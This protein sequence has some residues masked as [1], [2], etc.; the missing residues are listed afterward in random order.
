MKQQLYL[1]RL[2]LRHHLIKKMFQNFQF[3]KNGCHFK[4][5]KEKLLYVVLIVGVM[6]S[7]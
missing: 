7:S 2:I 6:K 3:L 5:K 1:Q 4:K